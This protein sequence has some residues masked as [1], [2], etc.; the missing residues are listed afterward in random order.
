VEIAG[1]D[2]LRRMQGP[3]RIEAPKRRNLEME[4]GAD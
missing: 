3:R 4:S 2:A 1:A